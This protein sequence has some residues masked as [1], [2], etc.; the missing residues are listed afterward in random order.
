MPALY[1]MRST[2]VKELRTPITILERLGASGIS[3]AATLSLPTGELPRWPR[4]LKASFAHA[5]VCASITKV[6]S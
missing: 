4:L 3:F 5:P 2:T 6:L 1:G